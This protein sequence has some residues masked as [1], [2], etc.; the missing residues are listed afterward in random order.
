M[1]TKLDKT[2]ASGLLTRAG[3]EISQLTYDK[4]KGLLS[5]KIKA[6]KAKTINLR[7][8]SG[9]KRFK[10]IGGEKVDLEQG[11]VTGL[12]LPAGKVI[13]LDIRF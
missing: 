1:P 6:K 10:A 2:E 12:S 4:R 8:P 9:T 3:V 11:M 5:V 13:A 7:L